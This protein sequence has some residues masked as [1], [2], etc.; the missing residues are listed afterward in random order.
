MDSFGD[1][2]RKKRESSGLLL[3]EVAARIDIDPSLL[4]RI[5]CSKKRPQ[6]EM[7]IKLAKVL[8]IDEDRLIIEYLSEKIVYELT[9]EDLA[10]SAVMVAEERLKYMSVKK[11]TVDENP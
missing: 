1:L 10:L 8:E 2:I 9:G 5:E 4:S 11:S 6:R 7:V 3:R